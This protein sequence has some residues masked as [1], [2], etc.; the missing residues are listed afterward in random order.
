MSDEQTAAHI[1]GLSLALQDIVEIMHQVDPDAVEAKLRT[2][3]LLHQESEA[4]RF[5]ESDPQT[6]LAYRLRRD[7]LERAVARNRES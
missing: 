1:A 3:R 7:L 6:L 2:A 4:G 5:R